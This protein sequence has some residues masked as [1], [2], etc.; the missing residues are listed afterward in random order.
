MRIHT[1]ES[2]R[3]YDDA[4]QK[5]LAEMDSDDLEMY[6]IRTYPDLNAQGLIPT[7]LRRAY[8]DLSEL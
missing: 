8:R 6:M 3:A 1:S 2:M 4:Q 5:I 7:I